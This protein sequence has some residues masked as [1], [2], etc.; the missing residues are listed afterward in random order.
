MFSNSAITI[1]PTYRIPSP[2]QTNICTRN[3]IQIILII[4]LKASNGGGTNI[5]PREIQGE[6]GETNIRAHSTV[7]CYY[8][9][10]HIINLR[11]RLML[12]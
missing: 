2:R 8:S 9:E 4:W 3:E 6:G 5:L 11:T 1:A 10:L 7:R 12:N